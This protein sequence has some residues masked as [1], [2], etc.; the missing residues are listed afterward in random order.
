[1]IETIKD[2]VEIGVL[3]LTAAKLIKE[4]TDKPKSKRK[5]KK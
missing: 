3:L 2:L 4:L 5:G 1:M